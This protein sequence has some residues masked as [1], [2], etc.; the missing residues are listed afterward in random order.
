MPAFVLTKNCFLP[1]KNAIVK[2]LF[3]I[4]TPPRPHQPSDNTNSRV[5]INGAKF[6]V[7]TLSS[8]GRVTLKKAL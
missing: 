3:S 6:H 8:F 1:S 7:C 5:M 4:T 2:K